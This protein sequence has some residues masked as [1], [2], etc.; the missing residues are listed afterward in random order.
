MPTFKLEKP[1]LSWTKLPEFFI[2]MLFGPVRIFSNVS[3][4]YP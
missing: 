2:A 1:D 4:F 3:L